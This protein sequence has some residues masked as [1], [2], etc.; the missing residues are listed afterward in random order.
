MEV[1]RHV[2]LK[3]WCRLEKLRKKAQQERETKAARAFKKDIDSQG[4]PVTKHTVYGPKGNVVHGPHYRP[5]GF[6]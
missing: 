3:I 6:K 2:L 5:G 4:R 1:G